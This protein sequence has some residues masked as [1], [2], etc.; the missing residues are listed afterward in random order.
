VIELARVLR[1]S[2]ELSAAESFL[3]HVV[4]FRAKALGY[5]HGD[6]LAAVHGAVRRGAR[7]LRRREVAL[8]RRARGLGAAGACAGDAATPSPALPLAPPPLPRPHV[9]AQPDGAA[10]AAALVKLHIC[11]GNTNLKLHSRDVAQRHYEAAIARA[12]QDPAALQPDLLIAW[13]NLAGLLKVRGF[14]HC[15]H[16]RVARH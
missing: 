8:Q 9:S 14:V 12:E 16:C 15:M 3:E 13:Y 6:T 1:A 2:G 5:S 7:R 4:R 11:V 10:D